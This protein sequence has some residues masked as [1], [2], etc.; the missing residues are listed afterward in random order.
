MT[1]EPVEP[2]VDATEDVDD[3]EAALLEAFERG[4]A[5]ATEAAA[6]EDAEAE[7]DLPPRAFPHLAAFVEQWF[8][9]IGWLDVEGN[10]RIWCP[11]WW[12]H[13]AAI[14]RLEAIWRAFENL[15]QDPALGGSTWLKDH[16][17]YHMA[18]LFDPNGPFKGCSI[19][20]GHDAARNRVLP[21][22]PAPADLFHEDD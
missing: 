6:L 2:D 3:G 5:A 19:S 12:K 1:T 18:V 13:S 20:R 4:W 15:R 10:T 22:K 14:V 11:E 8:A 21:V 7:P 17:D 16:A 9:E